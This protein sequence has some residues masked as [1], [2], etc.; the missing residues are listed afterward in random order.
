MRLLFVAPAPPCPN[1]GGGALRMYHMAR[2]LGRRFAVD[3]V[4]PALEDAE[5][6]RRLLQPF[7]GEIELVPPAARPAWRRRLHVG[8]YESDPAMREAVRRRLQSGRYAVVHVEKPAALPV[9]PRQVSVPIV[10]DTFAYGLGGAVR[11]LRHERGGLTP[12]RNLVRLLRY[13]AFDAFCWP[14][15]HCVLVVS[16][17]DRARCLKQRP[18]RRVLVVPNGV[19]CAAIR[20]GPARDGARPVFLFTGDLSFDPNVHAACTLISDIFPRLRDQFPEAELRLVG[21][22]PHPRILAIRGPG[23]A[24]AADVPE[25]L[26]HLQ[27]AAVYLA[28]LLTGA[29]TRTK[30][31]EAMA[32]GLPIV[33]TSVGLE[34]IAARDGTEVRIAED[35]DGMAAAATRLLREP[36][37]GRRLG[38]AARQLAEERYDWPKCLAPLTSLYGEILPARMA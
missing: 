33:T 25:M 23:V 18:G 5:T 21:R 30:L 34:G 31:L 29:G 3:L 32:A 15:T 36:A 17:G 11:A 7:C 14:A 28:P 6:A 9:L 1:V 37:E 35:A 16:D 27:D 22:N 20:P 12:V 26:P 13:A 8:P 4:A 24:I 38:Q 19:D 2:F 10:L